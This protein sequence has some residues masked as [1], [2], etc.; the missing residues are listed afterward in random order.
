MIAGGLAVAFRLTARSMT[1]GEDAVHGVVRQRAAFAVLERSFR[2]ASPTFLPSEKEPALYFRGEPGKVRFLSVS[3]LMATRGGGYRLLSF[4]EGRLPSGARGLMLSEASP[5]RT[6]GV[7]DW[8]GENSPRLV[9][10][11]AG[12]V[13]F[14]YVSGFT[15]EGRM[16]TETEWDPREKKRLPVAV[17]VEFKLEGESE[18][19]RVVI[20]LP[21]GVNEVPD[22]RPPTD[23]GPLG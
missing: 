1:Q 13:T 10:A 22:T 18:K 19:R 23:P 8:E 5:F 11:G 20:P 14:F 2:C 15:A 17:G 4:Y 9:L 7:D 3:P 16:E 6:A 12:G 21:V